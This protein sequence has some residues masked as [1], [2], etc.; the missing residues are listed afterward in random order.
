MFLGGFMTAQ[1]QTIVTPRKRFQ[2]KVK[3]WGPWLV[4]GLIFFYLFRQIRPTEVLAT[5]KFISVGPF[6]LYSFLYFILVWTIDCLALKHFLTRFSIPVTL[7]EMILVRGVSYL[8]M[9]INYPLSQGAFAIYLKKT[10][11]AKIAKTLGT[12]S[13]I[14]IADL[15][16][17]LTSALIAL[18]FTSP[19]PFLLSIQNLAIEFIL[20][21]Y[22][23]YVLWIWFWKKIEGGSLRGLKKYRLIHWILSHD[24]FLIFREAKTKDYLLLFGYRL[25]LLIVIIGGYN[26]ALFSFQS[27]LSWI[28]L[29]LYNPIIL[30]ILA[31][32]ITPGGLGTAQYFTIYFFSDRIQGPLLTA[33][34]ITAENLLFA[35]NLAWAFLNQ[36]YKIAFGMFFFVRG[37][38]K[39]FAPQNPE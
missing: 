18:V 4:C 17:V 5:L 35:S 39:N 6:V 8:F 25:P 21:I 22:L 36:L 14:M 19:D 34:K 11:N 27:S 20:A 7:K 38:R 31:L 10:H 26:F 3:I 29:Y 2:G 33:G 1:A 13:F 16:L 37:N 24:I 15:L 12:L 30:L 23:G 32:P 9:I 28:D